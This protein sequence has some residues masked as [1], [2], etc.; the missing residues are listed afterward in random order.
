MR[1]RERE[2][3]SEK[4]MCVYQYTVGVSAEVDLLNVL[5]FVFSNQNLISNC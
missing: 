2:K 5:A 4:L 3:M 1:D